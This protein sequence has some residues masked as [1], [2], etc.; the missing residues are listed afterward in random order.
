MVDTIASQSPLFS[1][2]FD[3]T[4]LR[5]LYCWMAEPQLVEQSLAS[6]VQ[7][8]DQG[9]DLDGPEFDVVDDPVRTEATA[10]GHKYL[11]F[12]PEQKITLDTAKCGLIWLCPR[13]WA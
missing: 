6:P 4:G 11:L 2:W 9:Y 8:N 12:P 5:C 3:G 13:R 7:K 10:S 1:F